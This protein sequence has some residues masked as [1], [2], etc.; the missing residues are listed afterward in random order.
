[1]HAVSYRP[2][3][4]NAEHKTSW[5]FYPSVNPDSDWKVAEAGV[6]FNL[7]ENLTAVLLERGWHALISKIATA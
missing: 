7:V 6:D 4:P 3:N 1:M 5:T 2:V